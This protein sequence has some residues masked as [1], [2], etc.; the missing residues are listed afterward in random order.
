MLTEAERLEK[1]SRMNAIAEKVA[2][3]GT[4]TNAERD[5]F[6]RLDMEF[7][8]DQAERQQW[9]GPRNPGDPVNVIS[10]KTAAEANS[11]RALIGRDTHDLPEPGD[12]RV[13]EAR[14]DL[15][16]YLSQR[17]DYNPSGLDLDSFDRDAF[18]VQL[19]T[20][21]THGREYRALAEGS[22]SA[23]F[24]GA[25]VT[26]PIAF[27]ANVLEMLRA[28]LVFTSPS[29]DGAI[30]GPQVVDMSTQIE[31]VPVWSADAA[32]VASYVGENPTLTPGTASLGSTLLTA[33]TIASVQLASR[34]LVDDNATT[35]G[36]AGLIEAN[37]ARALARAMD[38]SALYGTGSPQPSGLFT[39]AYSGSLQTVS[40]GTN[41]AAPTNYDQVSQA[42]EKVRIA[43]DEPTGIYTN[44][45][46][47]GTYSRLKNTQNDAM[48]PGQDVLD[49]WRPSYSTA[50]S[51]TETQGTSSLCSSALVVNANRIIM[52][53]RQ[54][55][56]LSTLSER[57]AD[58]LQYGFLAY[59]RHDW[60][61]PYSAA[62]CRVLGILT[63]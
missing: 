53:L 50:F 2:D 49:Y 55:L 14:H 52:G 16:A 47:F 13:L 48:R 34:Q 61:F 42:I 39:A 4:I 17:S 24:T 56:V 38:T 3:G 26:V 32:G 28:N 35:G 54:G 8:A 33:R 46:V 31:Y 19:I 11:R 12:G 44:P 15:K 1:V 45:Q 5:E 30:N 6:D 7:R 59:L 41:G 40:M 22:Q 10:Q 23:T 57:Y 62:A 25:G 29:A 9:T 27:A 58:S 37:V 60:S 43:N 36:I 18:W 51:A 20:G 63:T 21:Q